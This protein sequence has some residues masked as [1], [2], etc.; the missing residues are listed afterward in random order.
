MRVR[1]RIRVRVRV[2]ASYRGGIEV[3]ISIVVSSFLH[4]N[5]FGLDEM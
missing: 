1:V 2:R 3:I 5:G 4:F